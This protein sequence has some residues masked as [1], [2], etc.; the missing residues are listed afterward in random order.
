MKPNVKQMLLGIFLMLVSIWSLIFG[1]VDEVFLFSAVGV[2]LPI[3]AV[4][5][6]FLGFCAKRDGK[7]K[8]E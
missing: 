7:E 5:C 8:D 6:F 4:I 2:F 3:I 1:V